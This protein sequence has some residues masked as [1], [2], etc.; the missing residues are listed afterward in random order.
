M[1]KLFTILM[2]MI[3]INCASRQ[4]ADLR[5]QQEKAPQIVFQGGDGESIDDAVVIVGVSKQD[6]G[7]DAE[8]SFISKKNGLKGKDWRIVGQTIVKENKKLYDMI[9]FELISSS[10]RRIF[11]F[12]VSA[13]PWKN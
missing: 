11:Y 13:F 9:E 10:E 1:L 2:M 8:Y 5:T 3:L 6:E 7:M 4:T 12:D